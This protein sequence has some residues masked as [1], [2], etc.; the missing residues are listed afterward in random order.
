MFLSSFHPVRRSL[1]AATLLAAGLLL[2]WP[3]GPSRAG[4]LGHAQAGPILD[5]VGDVLP[6]C[7][8][9][10]DPGL[11]RWPTASFSRAAEGA[12]SAGSIAPTQA[13]GG[14][15]LVGP[16]RGRGTSRSLTPPAS[17]ARHRA[18]DP[19]RLGAAHQPGRRRPVQQPRGREI[20]STG[21]CRHQHRRQQVRRQRAAETVA[22]RLAPVLQGEGRGV[23]GC[24]CVKL[25][26]AMQSIFPSPRARPPPEVEARKESSQQPRPDAWEDRRLTGSVPPGKVTSPPRCSVCTPGWM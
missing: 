23:R 25:A 3:R 20:D 21:A 24:V 14:V 26:G 15:S 7:A 6:T 5:P 1:T 16:D 8:S 13:I 11:T 18:E 22:V 12:S 17:P 2:A 10:H 4:P 9:L 19:V